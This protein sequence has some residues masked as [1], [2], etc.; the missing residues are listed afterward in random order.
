[1]STHTLAYF[2]LSFLPGSS[3]YEDGYVLHVLLLSYLLLGVRLG[4]VLT[5]FVR[6]RV[7]LPWRWRVG[8]SY[9]RKRGNSF[10][11]D[12]DLIRSDTVSYTHLTLP[13]ILLV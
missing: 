6:R 5:F 4:L 8:D 7:V 3:S 13:T 10:T 9:A 11:N 2:K 12:T 1:M